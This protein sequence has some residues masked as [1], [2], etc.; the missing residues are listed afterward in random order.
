M[1]IIQLSTYPTC[2]PLH[3]G[4]I[5]VSQIR[6]Y[7]E[8]KGHILKSLSLSETSHGFYEKDDFIVSDNELRIQTAVPL[9]TD[10]A[11]SLL[12]GDSNSKAFEF[13]QKQIF[14]FEPDVIFLEQVWL[15]PAVKRLMIEQKLPL[16]VSVV[17]SS[18]NIEYKTKKALLESHNLKA[19]EV[20]KVIH[21]IY[22][23]EHDLCQSAHSVIA[24]TEADAQEFQ[25]LGARHTIVCNNGIEAKEIDTEV[26]SVLMENL[27][28]RKYALF[29]GSAYPPNALGFWA[30]LGDSLAWLPP[31][32]IIVVAGG[33]S[34]I[35][36]NYLSKEATRY[37]HVSFDRI[38][39]LGFVSEKLLS[40]LI[41][42]ASVVL[43]P[44][45]VGGGSNLKTA[46]AI[47]S[48]RPIVATTTACRGFEVTKNLS[49]IKITDNS[50]EF[51][52]AMLA[53][54]QQPTDI[55][56]TV[57]EIKLRSTVYW[58]E[59]LKEIESSF[60]PCHTKDNG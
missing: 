2:K 15:W 53:Y 1:K 32:C 50:K 37:T 28:G 4:Q 52:K 23:L 40:S 22:N 39:R 47:A 7:L 38:K 10:Y 48:H 54:L 31:D 14:A 58:N 26:S 20:E 25:A 6:K 3:G 35:L 56:L 16:H 55:T 49:H 12:L 29:V 19:E 13:L 59:T 9:C 43:L 45:T 17:Y 21:G 33:V 57:D 51:C 42:N 44:I 27:D 46:E 24:C 41:E 11:T 34:T 18:Q 36:E 5:R 8:S 60:M 30:M